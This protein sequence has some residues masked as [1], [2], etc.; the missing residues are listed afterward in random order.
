MTIAEQK[1]D[2]CGLMVDVTDSQL[3]T[4]TEQR[5]R[6]KE[7]EKTAGMFLIG[8]RK[9]TSKTRQR[10]GL[11]RTRALDVVISGEN[12]TDTVRDCLAV[13]LGLLYGQLLD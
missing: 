11:C 1:A 12:D 4:E 2:G 10:C 5:M 7:R 13:F 6:K 9:R 3:D 8:R